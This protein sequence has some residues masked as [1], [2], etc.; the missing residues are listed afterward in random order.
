M[1]IPKRLHQRVGV[2]KGRFVTI[3]DVEI[4]EVTWYKIVGISWSSYLSY[5]QICKCG[6]RQRSHGNVGMNK[7]RVVIRQVESNVW[8]LID[9]CIDVMPHQMKGIGNGRQNVH[10]L[11]PNIWKNVRKRNN[12][13][14]SNFAYYC[15]VYKIICVIFFSLFLLM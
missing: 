12:E 15:N 10:L 5:K 7:Q 6:T 1:D 13:V 8:S 14:G 3:N 4:C 11:I 9:Q 2:K